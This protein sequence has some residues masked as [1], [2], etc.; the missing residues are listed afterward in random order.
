[1]EDRAI[2]TPYPGTTRD[3]IEATIN[4]GGIPLRILDTAGIRDSADPVE[5]EGIKKSRECI[6]RAD[7]VI[8]M[9][10]NTDRTDVDLHIVEPTGEDLSKALDG[11]AQ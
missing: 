3:V 6:D 4:A 2:V 9:M 5:R 11:V 8:M 1:M 10:W 7:L